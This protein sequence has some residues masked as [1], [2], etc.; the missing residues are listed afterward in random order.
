[1]N[2]K[3]FVKVA[4]LVIL[5]ICISSCKNNENKDINNKQNDIAIIT[6]LSRIDDG[7][8]IQSAWEGIEKYAKE[9]KKTCKDYTPKEKTELSTVETIDLAVKNGAKVVVIPGMWFD[10]PVY[11]AQN[12]YPDTKF[13]LIDCLPI[14]TKTKKPDIAKNTVAKLFYQQDAGFLA[15]YSIVK[16]GYKNIGF[17]GGFDSDVIRQYGYSFI[18]GADYAAKQ[19]GLGEKSIKIKY[20][21]VGTF[22]ASPEIEDS[23]A[24]WYGDNTQVIF[25]CAGQAGISVM[26]AAQNYD[27]CVVGVDVDQSPI[28]K[29]VITSAKKNIK[30]IVYKELDNI[31]NNKFIG[32]QK[33]ILSVKTGDISL[34]MENS[35]FKKFNAKDYEKIKNEIVSGN[36]V[37]NPDITK[38]IEEI[39]HKYTEVKYIK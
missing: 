2:K 32:G 14:N 25:A 15:G 9:H 12:K 17:M 3:V 22:N 8:Y 16:E 19:M 37:I 6:T 30:N 34:E 7:S 33:D 29:S 38:P 11:T 35:R 28:S 24:S 5:A 1:M 31:Y 36:I 18:E 39:D 26:K 27:K 10:T 4:F 20:T 23:A 13:V 21:Y